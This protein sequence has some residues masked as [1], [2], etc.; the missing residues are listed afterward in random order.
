VR[1]ARHG[2]PGAER[3]VISGGDRRWRDL[4]PLTKDITAE[5]LG[6]GLDEARAALEA[7]SLPA[8]DVAQRFGP[9]IASRTPALM[10]EAAAGVLSSLHCVVPVPAASLIWNPVAGPPA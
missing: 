8:I 2:S 9:P 1:L 3:P 7:G 6:H 4:S 10:G 5:F